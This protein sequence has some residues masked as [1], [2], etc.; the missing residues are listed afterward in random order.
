MQEPITYESSNLHGAAE[1][2]AGNHRALPFD[3]EAMV[4][5]EVERPHLA[6]RRQFHSGVDLKEDRHTHTHATAFNQFTNQS[7]LQKGQFLQF[8]THPP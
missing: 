3:R 6:P 5:A 7:V 8:Y 1:D 2:R 4:N